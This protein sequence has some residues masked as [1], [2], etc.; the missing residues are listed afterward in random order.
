MQ[1]DEMDWKI[2]KILRKGFESN[3]AI[4]RKL[5]VSEGMI[6]KRITRLKDAGILVVRGLINPEVLDHQQIAIIGVNVA[7][8][9]LLDSKAR[10][11]AGLPGVH[12]V[13]IVSGRYDLIV[14]VMVD[15]NKGLVQF[16][17][18]T[19]SRVKGILKTESFLLLKSYHKYV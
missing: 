13:S 14:E 19:L 6:R 12:S 1:P 4:A 10:E 11:I 18:Q 16:L 15:S 9:K 5:G 17:T 8:S 3:N 2:T 7:E